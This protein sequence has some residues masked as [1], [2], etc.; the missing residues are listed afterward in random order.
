MTN[1]QKIS[2]AIVD[3]WALPPGGSYKKYSVNLQVR[4][5]EVVESL[6]K[7]F[8]DSE[9]FD[10]VKGW[11]E[12]GARKEETASL[13]DDREFFL[14]GC[15]VLLA[16]SGVPVPKATVQRAVRGLPMCIWYR[17][18]L[19]LVKQY[20]SETELL[21][22]LLEGMQNESKI[23]LV[24]N[25]LEGVR[26]YMPFA[27]K[28]TGSSQVRERIAQKTESLLGH[29]NPIIADLARTAAR[30]LAKRAESA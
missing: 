18:L 20:L 25:C 9:I 5:S 17:H 4:P 11:I 21:E 13:T 19:A 12:Y 7:Q 30:T 27:A 24:E 2:D 28:D 23:R 22:T 14:C 1:H 29:G 6:R 3:I 8:S 10:A 16:E 26:A 15:A